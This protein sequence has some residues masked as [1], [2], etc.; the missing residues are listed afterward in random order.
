MKYSGLLKGL[1]V[2]CVSGAILFCSANAEGLEGTIQATSLNIRDGADANAL[3]I[4]SVPAKTIV[5][6]ISQ[7]GDFY[8]VKYNGVTGYAAAEYIAVSGNT[9]PAGKEGKT[10]CGSVNMRA[11]SSAAYDIIAVLPADAKVEIEAKENDFYKVTY[12]N[13]TGYIS[14]KFIEVIFEEEPTAEIQTLNF[15]GFI[16]VNNVNMRK[17]AS[18]SSPILYQLQYGTEVTVTGSEN[19]FYKIRYNGVNGYIASNYISRSVQPTAK[20]TASATKSPTPLPKATNT[21]KTE[22]ANFTGY[23]NIDKVN[24]RSEAS[25]ASEIIYQLS[26]GTAVQVT[27]ITDGF[28][29]VKYNNHTGFIKTDY[30]SKKNVSVSSTAT[31]NVT[32]ASTV[33]VSSAK[34]TGYVSSD[35]LNVRQGPG[36]QYDII[37]I[38][39]KNDSVTLTGDTGEYYRIQV[40]G[41][42]GYV[43][44]DYI[45]LSK[46]SAKVAVNVT[47]APTA[48]ASVQ[49]SSAPN[50]TSYN[51]KGIVSSTSVN[52][53][54]MPTTSAEIIYK[55]SQNTEFEIT[56]ISG[57]F[58]RVKYSGKTG[59]VAKDYVRISDGKSSQ[60][61]APKSSSSASYSVKSM[62]DT[63]RVNSGTLNVR[64][65]PSSAAGIIGKLSVNESVKI[66][67][68]SGDYY[69]ISYNG[70]TGYVMTSYVTLSSAKPTVSATATKQPVS[71]SDFKN[72]NQQGFISS[73]QVNLRKEPSTGSS[74]LALLSK[75]TSVTV[76][77]QNDT[78]YKIKCGNTTGYIVKSYVKLGTASTPKATQKPS[79]T[80]SFTSVNSNGMITTDGVNLRKSASTDSESLCRLNANTAVKVTAQN[81]DFY[82]VT[83][84]GKTG[85][86]VK[87]YVKLVTSTAKPVVTAAPSKSQFAKCTSISQLG[88]APGYLS[89]G[90]TGTDVEKLQQALK[91]KGFYAGTV[92]GKFGQST[93]DAVLSYQK[94]AGLSQTGKA[95]YATIKKLFGKVS[96]TSVADDPKM[97]G[98]TRISD[99][100][101]PATSKKGN[102]GKNVLALQQA[103]K[104]KG[105]YKAPITSTFDTNTYNAVISYQKARGI[106]QTGEADF[107]T[108]KA[109]FGTN[110]ANY[111]YVTEEIIWF[112]GGSEIIPKGAVFTVKDVSTGLTYRA[113]RWSGGN[114]MDCE[115]LTAEDTAIM[116]RI[117]GGSWSWTRHAILVLYNGH[118]YAGSQNA[119]PHGTST[120]SN[121]NFDGHYC[122][123]FTGSMTHGSKKVDPDHQAAIKRALKAKW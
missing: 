4:T 96:V 73:D 22:Q 81:N 20:T 2:L 115:P 123:H 106:S 103:L 50:V 59:Y 110:A 44:K 5:T 84:N 83:Y 61:T 30:V 121:N 32:P 62:S 118:V 114:H 45:S 21:P 34:G 72:V 58:Y 66:T 111:T 90:N 99:I 67:G 104:I 54:S 16:N 10:V 100:T 55:I 113:K 40:N 112:K 91:I 98:I 64:E 92:D 7:T 51:A 35:T 12:Q 11:G 38:L 71:T 86:I 75:N 120:I 57:D 70:S 47:S 17:S 94:K 105:F 117:Y 3:V 46:P 42:T 23:I 48:K 76:L 60:T 97:N 6:V 31:A 63:G 37:L 49:Q 102:S 109:L 43:S 13:K 29:K 26:K 65:A 89:M 85:Y 82:K 101:V 107:T 15:K 19:G 53:R 108:I 28:Y 77:A 25:A 36:K 39:H 8:K 33:Q 1:S 69:R 122:I 79:A 87:N 88:D 93:K 18:S 52:M 119:M 27:G 68:I 78:W 56:G 24:M 14:C 74:S 9:S 95:D 41:K 80:S 116:K